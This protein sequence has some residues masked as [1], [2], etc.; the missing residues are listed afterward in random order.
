MARSNKVTGGWGISTPEW[1]N[2]MEV[3]SF[4]ALTALKATIDETD[5]RADESP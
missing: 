3:Q 5:I 2:E 1:W 4:Q